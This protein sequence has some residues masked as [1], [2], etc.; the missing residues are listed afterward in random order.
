MHYLYQSALIDSEIWPQ[1]Q[2]VGFD[3]NGNIARGEFG[4]DIP[5]TDPDD[6]IHPPILRGAAD[7]NIGFTDLRHLLESL[8]FQA[9]I[10][11]DH[12]IYTKVGSKAKPYQVKQVRNLILKYKLAR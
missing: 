3:L 9:R 11:G 10:K 2:W 12:F 8:G 5:S 6:R 7:N 4:M 1:I